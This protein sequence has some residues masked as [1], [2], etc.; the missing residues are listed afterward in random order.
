MR[1]LRIP[2]AGSVAATLFIPE[3]DIDFGEVWERDSYRKN[4]KNLVLKEGA[5]EQKASCHY[6]SW[7]VHR[8]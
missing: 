4:A 7:W 2:V 6:R 8:G 5:R 3:T 1:K